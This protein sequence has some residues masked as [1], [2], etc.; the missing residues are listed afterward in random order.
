MGRE[1]TWT[2][3]GRHD[4]GRLID[5]A[6]TALSPGNVRTY[7]AEAMR[8]IAEQ[9][10][11]GTSVLG[12]LRR[13]AQLFSPEQVDQLA[14]LRIG[15]KPFPW[16]RVVPLLAFKKCAEALELARK[17]AANGWA[18]TRLSEEVRWSLDVK[19]PRKGGR[20]PTRSRDLTQLLLDVRRPA[21]DLLNRYRWVRS[22][23][24]STFAA[25]AEGLADG[26][27]TEGLLDELKSLGR[28][29]EDNVHA[30]GELARDVALAA[31]HVGRALESRLAGAACTGTCS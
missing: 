5:G 18:T 17:A 29:L 24:E 31:E 13:F 7:G 20:R 3:R 8:A 10:E 23:A 27:L 14:A 16:T 6:Y 25:R 1:V 30:A 22:S 12:K 28:D 4:L 26:E 9:T 2:L 21:R 19:Q 11:L 15:K